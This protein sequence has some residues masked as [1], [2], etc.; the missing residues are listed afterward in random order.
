MLIF[1]RHGRSEGNAKN[2]LVGR[3]DLD[4]DPV[5]HRQIEM[6]PT[7]LTPTR[8][9]SSPL[10]RCQ[11]TAAVF[12][13]PVEIEP[14]VIEVDY[15]VYDL[16]PLDEIPREMWARW[17]SDPDFVPPGG[18]SMR[19]MGDRV[20]EVCEEL[21]EQAAHTDIVVVSHVSPVKAAAA[22]A[23]GLG[24]ADAWRLMVDQASITRIGRGRGGHPMLR[25]FNETGH[26]AGIE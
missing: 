26:L 20:R 17:R 6:L 1:V 2:L 19:A 24:D 9:I 16:M 23:V 11:V 15:G 7:V 12:G 14:R 3:A 13:L 25:S 21:V 22:W 5:G 18:E 10:V 4:L 8:V